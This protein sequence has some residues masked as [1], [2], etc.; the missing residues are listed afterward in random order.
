L[1]SRSALGEGRFR[2]ASGVRKAE[3]RQDYFCSQAADEARRR[4]RRSLRLEFARSSLEVSVTLSGFDRTQEYAARNRGEEYGRLTYA[5]EEAF[6]LSRLPCWE[7]LLPEEYRKRVAELVEKIELDARVARMERESQSWV[8]MPFCGRDPTP[9]QARRRGRR[10]RG[11]MPRA[12]RSG[13]DCGRHM[14]STFFSGP[15]PSHRLQC[16]L[17]K[18][19]KAP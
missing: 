13:M 1:P 16:Y 14:A 9:A 7:H 10:L 17:W 12:R 6:A 3:F 18:W 2:W 5:T 4:E 8:P 11:S 19:R 15:F